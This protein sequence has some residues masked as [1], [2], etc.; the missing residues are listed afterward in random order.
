MFSL[1]PQ[2]MQNCQIWRYF[3]MFFEKSANE[4][5]T[6]GGWKKHKKQPPL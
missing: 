1:I 5:Q 6:R 4:M 3:T 2:M